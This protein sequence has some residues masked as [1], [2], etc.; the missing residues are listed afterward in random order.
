MTRRFGGSFAAGIG[1]TALASLCFGTMPTIAKYAYREGADVLPLLAMRFSLT[2]LLLVGFHAVTCQSIRIP[3]RAALKLAG[4]GACGYAFESSLYFFALERA[5]AGVVSLVFYS[6]PLWTGILAILVGLERFSLRLAVA[7]TL[8][9]AGVTTIFTVGDAPLSGLLLALGSAG[10]V[11]VYFILAQ[12]TLVG[13]RPSI[14]ATWTSAGAAGALL[15]IQP[16]VPHSLP[17]SSFPWGVALAVATSLA[18]L[19]LYGGIARLGSSRT[20]IAAMVEPVVAVLLAAVILDE[21]ITIR[22]AIGAL[23]VISALPVLATTKPNER[24]A[25]DAI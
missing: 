4:V 21:E 2:T 16:F 19:G 23:L 6:Y 12:Y 18:F 17:V 3:A 10:A 24:P 11:A 25:S 13:V 15:I 20:A 22:V 9:G 8:G 7:L 5:P 14:A 1:L